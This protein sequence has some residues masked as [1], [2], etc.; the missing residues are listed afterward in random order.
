MAGIIIFNY[1][2]RHP[3]IE[4]K[5]RVGTHLSQV[6]YAD[7]VM[8]IRVQTNETTFAVDEYTHVLKKFSKA[9]LVRLVNVFLSVVLIT[10]TH[11]QEQTME[12]H[13]SNYM[14]YILTV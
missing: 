8:N 13:F 5:S 3:G 12:Q 10:F 14:V 1:T 9:S 4:H 11:H 2:I 7:D 6:T